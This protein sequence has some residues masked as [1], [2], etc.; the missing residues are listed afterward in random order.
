MPLVQVAGPLDERSTSHRERASGI[1]NAR[2]QHTA[3]NKTLA[4]NIKRGGTDSPPTRR[5]LKARSRKVRSVENM[6]R[7]SSGSG[8][9]GLYSCCRRSR[10]SRRLFADAVGGLARGIMKKGYEANV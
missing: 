7:P 5:A 1:G 6:R 3:L 9:C 4:T 8:K 10:A 2:G